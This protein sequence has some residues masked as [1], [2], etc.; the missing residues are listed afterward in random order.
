MGK[1][2]ITCSDGKTTVEC[3]NPLF[4]NI[5]KIDPEITTLE[6]EGVDMIFAKHRTLQ[7]S[8]F[9]AYIG[10][11][12]L[13]E[14]MRLHKIVSVL[15]MDALTRSVAKCISGKFNSIKTP[16]DSRELFGIAN[17]AGA[18]ENKILLDVFAG[19]FAVVGSSDLTLS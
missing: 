2:E 8:E 4:S 17:E 5:S 18:E 6:M 10:E 12:L 15:K 1:I 16:L 9:N 13:T 14:L 19:I 3:V 11:M 7:P